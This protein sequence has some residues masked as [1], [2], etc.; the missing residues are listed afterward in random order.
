M[1]GSETLKWLQASRHVLSLVREACEFAVKLSGSA[2]A[3]KGGM[4]GHI[5]NE[6]YSKVL[7]P[8][9]GFCLYELQSCSLTADKWPQ[10]FVSLYICCRGRQACLLRCSFSVRSDPAYTCSTW[11]F[12][13]HGCC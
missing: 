5:V 4:P 12:C 11:S 1:S 2:A 6:L 8:S 9:G 7:T 3:A 13:I 10:G